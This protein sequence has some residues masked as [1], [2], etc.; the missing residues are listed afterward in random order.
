MP[1]RSEPPV[2]RPW[3]ESAARRIHD[4]L[5]RLR[6]LQSSARQF[7]DFPKARHGAIHALVSHN[8]KLQF[9]LFSLAAIMVFGL[10]AVFTPSSRATA[11]PPARPPVEMAPAAPPPEVWLVETNGVEE[12]YSNGLRIDNRFSVSHYPRSYLAFPADRVS[13]AVQ[14]RD[15]AGIVFHSTESHIEP[16]ESGKNREL[17]RAGESLLEYVKRKTAYHFV[18]DRFGRVFRIVAEADSADHAGASVWADGEWLY[19]NLNA[20]FLGVALEARTEPGQTE[21]GASPAQLRATA[22]LVEMLRSRY[23]IPAANCVTHAQVSVNTQNSQAGYHTDWASSFPFGQVGLP[24]NYG[25]ALP[26]VWAFGF[27]A[28]PEFRTAAGTRIAES[29][30]IAEEALRATAASE[31]STP[32]AYR[33][34]LQ[35]W[36]RQRLK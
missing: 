12:S 34:R 26:A 32:G 17:R 21:S 36:Y 35:A 8:R 33:K 15:P 11:L 3:I 30:D 27:F 19:V 2:Y 25:Q 18:V 9:F 10:F 29:I 4:P 13:P 5:N 7:A 31:G 23:H 22:M 16:F 24:D 1:S 20:G 28:G 14:R 6:F